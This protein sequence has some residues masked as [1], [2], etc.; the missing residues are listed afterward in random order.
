MFSLVHP[1]VDRYDAWLAAHREW[2]PGLHED[3]FG[4]GQDDDVN[5]R[6]GFAAWIDKLRQGPGELWWIVE[7]GTVLGGIALR[8]VDDQRA[9]RH[10]HVGYGVRP[11]ARGRGVASWALQQVVDL[12][13][14]AGRESIALV[15]LSENVASIRTV[16]RCGGTVESVF[17]AGRAQR[18]VI[19]L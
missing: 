18:L 14:D 6:Q 7:D 19:E 8:A 2:G 16:E 17:D 15:C 11:S 1:S 12:A 4:I 9:A 3:G 10:G 13:R 5:S